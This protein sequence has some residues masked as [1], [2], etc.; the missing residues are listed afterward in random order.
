MEPRVKYDV[1]I[2]PVTVVS[3]DYKMNKGYRCCKSRMCSKS[4]SRNTSAASAQGDYI[5]IMPTLMLFKNLF[6][7]ANKKC[8]IVQLWNNLIALIEINFKFTN[9][10]EHSLF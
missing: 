9:Y 4:C 8:N 7:E 2:H 6:A 10:E 1:F 5:S 3:R